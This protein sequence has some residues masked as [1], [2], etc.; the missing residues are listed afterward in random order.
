M[1][2]ISDELDRLLCCRAVGISLELALSCDKFDL[3]KT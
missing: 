2:C 3:C 1:Y